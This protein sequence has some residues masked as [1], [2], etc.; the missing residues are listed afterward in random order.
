[1]I[2]FTLTEAGTTALNAATAGSN[3]VLIDSI[4]LN[5]NSTTIKTITDFMGCVVSDDS[6]IGDYVVIDFEDTTSTGYTI[7]QIKLKSGTTEIANSETLSVVK[8]S[9]KKLKIRITAQFEMA[10]KCSFDNTSINLPYATQF[11]DGVVR[12]AKSEGETQKDKTVYTAQDV[13]AVINSYISGTDQYVPWNVSGGTPVEGSVNIETLN[14]VDDYDNVTD[15]AVIELN[16]KT[17][18]VSNIS[19]GGYITGTAVSSSPTISSGAVTGSPKVVN[20]TYISNL[21]A[22]EV[23]SGNSTKLV[24]SYAVSQYVASQLQDIDDD[25]VHMTGNETVAGTKTFSD[26]VSST[27][28]TGSGVQSV[29]ASGDPAVPVWNASGNESKLPT[30]GVVDSAL[31]ALETSITL[32]YTTADNDL[33]SQID[34]LNAGQ[35]LADIVDQI[36]NL[37]SHSVTN[38]QARGKDGVTIGDKV[39]VLHD[40]TDATGTVVPTAD[41]VAT[42]YELV[43]GTIDTTTYPKDQASSTS[44]Y[45]WHYIG[46][47][48]CD[49]YSKSEADNK[50]VA[51]SSLDQSI[52]TTSSTTNAPSTK[53]VFDY[54]DGAISTAGGNY[55]KLTSATAQTIA[56]PLVIKQ[57]T[58]STA[59]LSIPDGQSITAN[60]TLTIKADNST[61]SVSTVYDLT[62]A[63]Y[64]VKLGSN[65]AIDFRKTTAATPLVDVS[66]DMVASYR[67]VTNGTLSDGRLVTV[68]YLN[69]FT[70]DMA[71]YAKVN[72]SNDFT[73]NTTPTTN[74]FNTVSA[75]SYTGT[76][77][78]SVYAS[79]DPA[80]PVWNA[81][82]NESK[83]PTVGVVNSALNDLKDDIL[84]DMSTVDEIGSIGLFVYSEVGNQ[85]GIGETVSGTYLKPAALSLPMSGQIS[86]KSVAYIDQA[87][88]NGLTGTWRLLSAAMKRT[89]T[90]PCLVLA[91][92]ISA[93]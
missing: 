44:G 3:P 56:S 19:V 81:S 55:V 89:A 64:T 48:G 24:T 71:A 28:Y 87:T 54:V 39:Q 5:N 38:L 13:E 75:S 59:T 36:A 18:Q 86:Y 9:N 21:Y 20:E 29:Y 14:L 80:V 93:T 15:T 73:N 79:G 58:A 23:S 50:Y 16:G 52:L 34:A 91:Q 61:N 26:G 32:A 76:G 83:L 27:S 49:S 22:N 67:S 25:Y 65:T 2:Q 41:G 69:A 70:G 85:K 74:T 7:T 4:V 68:D 46:E 45:Y 17:G 78:Q 53:A 51:K 92:K 10:S 63:A 47:Y 1:M 84:T 42:V 57:A 62:N 12:L 43:Y 37:T 60:N 33:Q 8:G 72:A 30:V 11:R 90:E 35:N 66:G 77:V 6:G 88:G 31:D 82:G 40:K